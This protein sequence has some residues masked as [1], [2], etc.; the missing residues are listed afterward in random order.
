MANTPRTRPSWCA[1]TNHCCLIELL[2]ALEGARKR[3]RRSIGLPIVGFSGALEPSWR[4]RIFPSFPFETFGKPFLMQFLE[5]LV[6]LWKTKFFIGLLNNW[7]GVIY[8]C[9]GVFYMREMQL[10]VFETDNECLKMICLNWFTKI[11]KIKNGE[12]IRIDAICPKIKR[13]K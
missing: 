7:R 4:E 6:G 9:T 5:F 13:S 8:Y 10:V 2:A 1:T 11:N 12:N 3:Q